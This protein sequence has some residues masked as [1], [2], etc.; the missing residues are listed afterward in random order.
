MELALHGEREAEKIQNATFAA[1]E[2]T[3]LH[4]QEKT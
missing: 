1:Y 4:I 2:T 3:Q